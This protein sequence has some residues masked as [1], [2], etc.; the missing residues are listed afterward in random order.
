MDRRGGVDEI[1]YASAHW[2]GLTHVRTYT[3]W[4]GWRGWAAGLAKSEAVDDGQTGRVRQEKRWLG[5]YWGLRRPRR[6]VYKMI[7]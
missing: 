1:M 7:Q 6:K 2:L 3:A 4:G 5:I